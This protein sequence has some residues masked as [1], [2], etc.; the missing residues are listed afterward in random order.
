MLPARRP[1]AHSRLELL[2]TSVAAT[3]ARDWDAVIHPAVRTKPSYLTGKD[4]DSLRL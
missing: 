4:V 2:P 3:L 1:V